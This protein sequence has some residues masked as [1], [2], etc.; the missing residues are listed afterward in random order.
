MNLIVKEAD[1]F[2]I[3]YKDSV[4][5][6]SV[7]EP[8]AVVK[9]SNGRDIWITVQEFGDNNFYSY[10]FTSNGIV[11]CAVVSKSISTPIGS[12]QAAYFTMIFSID[13]HYMAKVNT[14]Q[15]LPVIN[16]VEIYGF[17]SNDGKF[18]KLFTI[19]SLAQTTTG[20][21]FSKDNSL[22]YITERDDDLLFYK[23]YPT[24]SLSTINSKGNT[25]INGLKSKMQI[26][27]YGHDVAL[28]RRSDDFFDSQVDF[29]TYISDLDSI[30]VIERK[31]NTNSATNFVFPNFNQSYFNT[32][33][34]NLTDKIRFLPLLMTG[35][36]HSK[37]QH[38]LP[39]IQNPP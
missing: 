23:F 5:M 30:I 25:K 8:I 11:K 16:K 28:M 34:I 36:L 2:R 10:L 32:P 20:L 7:C 27:P 38:L 31:I 22:L 35:L 39:V 17:N 14:N 6:Y 37:A 19:D 3:V 26:L 24:D 29:L 13:G 21:C 33:S 18:N 1:T 15:V 9:A 4:L 12:P